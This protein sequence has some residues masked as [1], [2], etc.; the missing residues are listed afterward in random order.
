MGSRKLGRT[1]VESAGEDSKQLLIPRVEWWA[2]TTQTESILRSRSLRRGAFTV[3][4][5]SR[6]SAFKP[7]HS[8]S[9]SAYSI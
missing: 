8:E 9:S 3:L 6:S 7:N 4:I 1:G 2:T 5:H